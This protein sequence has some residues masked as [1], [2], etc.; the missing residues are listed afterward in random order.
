ME[1]SIAMPLRQF[2]EITETYGKYMKEMNSTEELLFMNDLH[3]LLAY[4]HAVKVNKKKR[5][6]QYSGS[7]LISN[8]HL[9]FLL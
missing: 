7:P 8:L 2:A 4:C 1:S 9:P 5:K 6:K 3:E